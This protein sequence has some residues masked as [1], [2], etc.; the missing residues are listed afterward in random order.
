MTDSL[1]LLSQVTKRL[2]D[3]DYPDSYRIAKEILEHYN[4]DSKQ[5]QQALER[6][7]QNEPWD[8]IRGY[9]MFKGMKIYVGE[10]VLIPRIE[11]EQIVD[12][13]KNRLLNSEIKMIIDI[14]TG[15][16][17]IIKTLADELGDGYEYIAI[18]KSKQAMKF[19]KQNLEGTHIELI[20]GDLLS[21]FKTNNETFVIAN[22]PY[23]PTNDYM[24]LDASV[25]D[26][27]PREA[28]DGG[29]NGIEIINKLLEQCAGQDLI[30]KIVLEIDPVTLEDLEQSVKTHLP[31]SKMSII[32]DY[33]GFNRFILI[34]KAWD[35]I[36]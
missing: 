28:L 4:N 36:N 8:Y 11:T 33:R 5:I 17:A 22:L 14:G 25:K 23:I 35:T 12:I 16:G 10:G 13:V 27:E 21:A 19:A 7:S 6:I 29:E 24:R 1:K 3:I 2:E 9:T 32:K 26:F 31:E 30:S 15:S 20:K 18:E 34:E